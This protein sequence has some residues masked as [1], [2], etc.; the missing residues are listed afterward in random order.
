MSMFDIGYQITEKNMKWLQEN[1]QDIVDMIEKR[2]VFFQL[3][4]DFKPMDNHQKISAM[5]I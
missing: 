5:K 1:H 3:H 2:D 4:Q